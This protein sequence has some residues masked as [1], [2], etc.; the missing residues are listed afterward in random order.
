MFSI[1]D[2]NA[3]DYTLINLDLTSFSEVG[4]THEI[5]DVNNLE[6]R[7]EAIESSLTNILNL[8]DNYLN[9]GSWR[10][11]NFSSSRPWMGVPFF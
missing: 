8:V 6:T 4:H 5:T 1:D 10:V 9:F 3:D 11:R 2:S 7:L